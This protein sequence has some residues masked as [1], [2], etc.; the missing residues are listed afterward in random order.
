M[1]A[2]RVMGEW[3]R[4]ELRVASWE[5]GV[6]ACGFI[7]SEAAGNCA[8]TKKG[9]RSPQPR[10]AH[11]SGPSPTAP[12]THGPTVLLCRFFPLLDVHLVLRPQS[13]PSVESSPLPLSPFL[14]PF[15]SLFSLV[16]SDC[17]V[18]SIVCLSVG[19]GTVSLDQRFSLFFVERYR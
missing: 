16:D 12:R 10:I 15:F 11:P 17:V 19:V 18:V 6:T 7:R 5:L 3:T 14:S 2:K 8:V 4:G 1:T 13:A 9:Q